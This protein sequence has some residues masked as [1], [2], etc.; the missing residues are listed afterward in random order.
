[1]LPSFDSTR[2]HAIEVWHSEIQYHKVRLEN[3]SFFN[4]RE[5]IF[6]LSTNFPPVTLNQTSKSTSGACG[7]VCDKYAEHECLTVGL[8]Q[9]RCRRAESA[10]KSG[11]SLCFAEAGA[12]VTRAEDLWL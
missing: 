1:M 5:A 11:T 3:C 10:L 6:G 12:M 4:C 9:W 7:L 2:L 8:V